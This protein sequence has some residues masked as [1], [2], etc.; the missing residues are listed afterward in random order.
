MSASMAPPA[1]LV[2]IAREAATML[3]DMGDLPGLARR[4]QAA[5]EGGLLPRKS[6]RVDIEALQSGLERAVALK[7]AGTNGDSFERS[8]AHLRVLARSLDRQLRLVLSAQARDLEMNVSVAAE[9]LEAADVTPAWRQLAAIP[10]R[11]MDPALADARPP[12]A[13]P[14]GFG[15]GSVGRISG[16]FH[17]AL[18]RNSSE[19]ASDTGVVVPADQFVR[20]EKGDA[21][22]VHVQGWCEG[23]RTSHPLKRQSQVLHFVADEGGA[24]VHGPAVIGRTRID[25]PTILEMQALAAEAQALLPRTPWSWGGIIAVAGALGIAGLTAFAASQDMTWKSGVESNTVENIL[26]IIFFSSPFVLIGLIIF[27]LFGLIVDQYSQGSFTFAWQGRAKKTLARRL[28]ERLNSLATRMGFQ[29]MSDA[30]YTVRIGR[31]R[32]TITNHLKKM[33]T[34]ALTGVNFIAPAR[35]E[36][37]PG[38]G[39]L[40]VLEPLLALPAPALSGAN[41]HHLAM[42]RA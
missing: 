6:M 42:A 16:R 12:L 41:V 24:I 27:G 38:A 14:T 33:R 30:K 18:K 5:G 13:L 20:F 10:S 7:L 39:A 4:L 32:S 8:L 2:A 9:S 21:F 28:S 36:A 19:I 37:A 11:V 35:M 31:F 15:E 3:P 26:M 23:D 25:G 34:Q 22:R 40:R 17:M 29:S 1:P